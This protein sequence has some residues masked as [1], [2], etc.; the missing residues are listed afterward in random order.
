MKAPATLDDDQ[1]ERLAELLEQRAVP[2][3]GFN[4]EALDGYLSALVVS[5]ETVPFEQ[6]QLP[7]WGTPPRWADEDERAQ[8]EALLQG[9]W[10]MV[11]QRV[12]FGDDDLPDHLAPLLWLPEDPEQEQEDE[13]DVGRD[14]AFGFFRGVELNEIAWDQR[15][16]EHGWIDEI[17]SLLDRLASGEV[18]AEDPTAAAT[19]ISYRERLEII[20]GLPGMLADLHHHRIEAL[21]PREPIRREATPDRNAACPCGSGRKFK[22][23]CGA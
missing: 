1:V 22:K 12:R 7:I 15:L 20:G 17:F 14:W 13:L 11:S 8:V 10:N 3:K 2:F 5:P 9:H 21:T 18:L 23:C 6:W 16:D 4:L 19:P